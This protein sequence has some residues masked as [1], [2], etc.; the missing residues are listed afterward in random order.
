MFLRLVHRGDPAGFASF[1]PYTLC[2]KADFPAATGAD[3]LAELAAHPD[4]YTYG[5]DGIGGTMQ[6]AAERIF[7]AKGVKAVAIP[8]GGA[9][10]TMQN[11]LGG[12]VDIYGGSISPVIPYVQSGEA[13]CLIVTTFIEDGMQDSLD[14]GRLINFQKLRRISIVIRLVAVWCL[15]C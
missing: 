14:K 5:N 8:F 6:L 7:Q 4:K 10:E 15:K 13:K 11:F 9:G 1:R 2:V 12:H 3:F